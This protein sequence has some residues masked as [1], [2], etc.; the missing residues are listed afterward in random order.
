MPVNIPL[1]NNNQGKYGFVGKESNSGIFSENANG[2]LSTSDAYSGFLFGRDDITGLSLDDEFNLLEERL[3]QKISELNAQG[4]AEEAQIYRDKLSALNNATS[5]DL[6]A[7]IEA[8]RNIIGDQLSYNPDFSS[9]SLKYVYS[10]G[11]FTAVKHDISGSVQSDNRNEGAS[12]LDTTLGRGF[13]VTI[14]DQDGVQG[15]NSA[16]ASLSQRYSIPTN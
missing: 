15:N 14:N 1:R 4:K 13:G 16:T 8:N 2:T 12:N 9:G 10:Q 3:T 11:L 5:Q 7:A 6:I